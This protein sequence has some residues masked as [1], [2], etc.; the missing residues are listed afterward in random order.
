MYFERCRRSVFGTNGTCDGTIA[1]QSFLEDA[2]G[3]ALLEWLHY[4]LL[5]TLEVR[6]RSFELTCGSSHLCLS[7]RIG[8]KR[9]VDVTGNVRN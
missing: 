7:V 3:V 1:W 9:V 8:S 4:C 5:P 2:I 6:V